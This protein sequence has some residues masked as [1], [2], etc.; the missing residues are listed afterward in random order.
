MGLAAL[1]SLLTAIRDL[2]DYSN[3]DTADYIE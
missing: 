2:G 3:F 1:Q